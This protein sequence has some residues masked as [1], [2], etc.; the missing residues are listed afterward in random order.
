MGETTGIEWTD[1]T[2]TPVRAHYDSTLVL[3]DAETGR[4]DEVRHQATGW[5]CE[6]VSEGCR[7]C[8]AETMNKRLGTGLDYKPGNLAP[9]GPVEMF[10]DEKLLL[11]PLK[12][13][14]P[15]R[16]FVCSM[17]DLFADF[18]PDAFIDRMF[19]VMALCPQHSFQ[20]L[21]KRPERMREYFAELLAS[22]RWLLWPSPVGGK[23]MFDPLDQSGIWPLPNV[24]LGVSVEDQAAADARIPLLLDTPAAV[25]FLS[26]EPLL[27]PVDLTAHLWGRP[28]PCPGCPKDID[29]D[30]NTL[31][32][33]MLDDEPDIAWV[34]CGGESGPGARPMHPDWA[35]GLR[36]QCAAAGVPF[37]FKQWGEWVPFDHLGGIH[38]SRDVEFYPEVTVLPD[39]T[40][41]EWHPDFP[42]TRP[43]GD[44]MRPVFKVGKKRAG[45]LLDGV[46]HDGM[47]A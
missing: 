46:Q 37:L 23:H 35:R 27:G 18:V 9:R 28:V 26:C 2:W 1:A 5:H 13:R 24:W 6:H 14:K 8:Y 16:I 4:V 21:T 29:C 11:A 41:R 45:R 33:H 20:V 39:G 32:R 15:K 25:R 47:P 40:V 30:C 44:N 3:R 19:A 7:N 17:T 31:P 42:R 36:D 12:W 22:A 43:T 10:L 38:L 34:I